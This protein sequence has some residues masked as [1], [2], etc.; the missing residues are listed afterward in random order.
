MR[1]LLGAIADWDELLAQAYRCC[2]P[3][4]WVESCEVDVLFVSDD[5]TVDNVPGLDVWNKL[6]EEGGKKGG[7]TFCVVAEDI[8]RKSMEAAGFT[9]IQTVNY[10]V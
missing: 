7:R 9:D 4:G 6:Y 5:G 1:Y 3:G 8:Q 2:Q 10:K